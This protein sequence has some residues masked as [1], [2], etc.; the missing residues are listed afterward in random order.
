MDRSVAYLTFH[1]PRI[2]HE[3]VEDLGYE[4]N[5][6]VIPPS[7]PDDAKVDDM[8]TSDL[9]FSTVTRPSLNLASA[10]AMRSKPNTHCGAA[11][12]DDQFTRDLASLL[13]VDGFSS[14]VDDCGD[15]PR[16]IPSSTRSQSPPSPCSPGGR[17][18][19]DDPPGSHGTNR[20]DATN[21][22]TNVSDRAIDD[23]NSFTNVMESAAVRSRGRSPVRC[24]EN[25]QEAKSGGGTPTLSAPDAVEKV[26]H[27][28]YCL[29]AHAG[30][31]SSYSDPGSRGPALVLAR[32]C[33]DPGVRDESSSHCR[34]MSPGA[35]GT[36]GQTGPL[37]STRLDMVC[38]REQGMSHDCLKVPH[39]VHR[40]I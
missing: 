38:N 27:M 28:T 32:V 7:T 4:G 10:A 33:A 8:N 40:N 9:A 26:G 25:G 13:L 5:Y 23:E 22:S 31:S 3:S 12:R 34:S 30:E 18:E 6:T 19:S 17:N 15:D 39:P 2:R 21:L 24:Y 20:T 29:R 36:G 14:G 16:S 1:E 37:S 35:P 11:N